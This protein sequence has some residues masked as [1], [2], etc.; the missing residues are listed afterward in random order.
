MS[1]IADLKTKLETIT[2]EAYTNGSIDEL[3]KLEILTD[4]DAWYDCRVA[5]NALTATDVQSYSIAG[6]S[7]TR[8][9]VPSLQKQADTLYLQIKARLYYRGGGLANII[10]ENNC[11][12]P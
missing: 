6:R 5:V 8:R 10:N 7:V 4:I 2:T 3:D 9:D 11:R 12:L 1:N